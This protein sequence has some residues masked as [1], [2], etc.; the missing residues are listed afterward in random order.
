MRIGNIIQRTKMNPHLDRDAWVEVYPDGKLNDLAITT[1][2][3]KEHLSWT[4]QV[5]GSEHGPRTPSPLLVR[6]SYY[7]NRIAPQ[8]TLPCNT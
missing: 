7:Q 4:A 3:P 2:I 5:F 1:R 8:I 6:Q